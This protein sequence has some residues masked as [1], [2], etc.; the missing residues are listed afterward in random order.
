[1]AKP[2]Q[3]GSKDFLNEMTEEQRQQWARDI[4]NRMMA[5]WQVTEHKALAQRL[6]LHGNTPSN[7][8]QKKSVPWTAIYTCHKETGTSLDWLYNGVTP[9]FEV[10]QP[11]LSAFATK[12]GI[13]FKTSEQM[14]LIAETQENGYKAVITGMQACFVEVIQQSQSH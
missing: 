8:I 2:N 7:W 9:Q 13:L 3:V 10:T 11:M 1:M 5:A 14:E 6:G 12:A 4:V